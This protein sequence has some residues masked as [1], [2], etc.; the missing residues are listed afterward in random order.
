MSVIV[1]VRTLVSHLSSS[2]YCNVHGIFS[3]NF[4]YTQHESL[5]YE[6]AESTTNTALTTKDHRYWEDAGKSENN[7]TETTTPHTHKKKHQINRGRDNPSGL[8]RIN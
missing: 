4:L 1:I 7:T 3:E 2:V 8:G 6:K 5:A